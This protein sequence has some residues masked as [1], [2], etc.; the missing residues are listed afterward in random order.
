MNNLHYKSLLEIGRLIQSGDITSVAVTEAL[1]TRID[2]L[3]S[4][5][6]SYFYVMRDSALKQ[7]TEAD[8]EIAAGKLRGPLHGVPIALKDLIWTKDAP[9]ATG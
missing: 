4:D 3:D 7:A 2:T 9:T 6:H 1:L 5:L 8:A